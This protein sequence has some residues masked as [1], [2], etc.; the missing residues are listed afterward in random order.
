M[1]R[2][3]GVA[4]TVEGMFGLPPLAYPGGRSQGY[5]YG[6]DAFLSIP[7]RRPVPAKGVPG[8]GPGRIHVLVEPV[9]G[10]RA[11]WMR[12]QARIGISTALH[13]GVHEAPQRLPAL[14]V[15]H[16]SHVVG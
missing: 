11:R 5:G 8:R 2:C 14:R 12:L 16:A 3:V 9:R 7:P 10:G 4:L 1:F 6:T 13:E 15:Y